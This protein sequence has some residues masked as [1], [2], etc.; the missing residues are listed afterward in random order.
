MFLKRRR[1]LVFSVAVIIL[2]VLVSFGYID[3][4][5]LNRPSYV[6]NDIKINDFSY[7]LNNPG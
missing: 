2:L 7:W 4:R 6:L 3:I 1:I 5:H